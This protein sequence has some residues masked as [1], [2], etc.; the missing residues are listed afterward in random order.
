MKIGPSWESLRAAEAGPGCSVRPFRLAGRL[1]HEPP[2]GLVHRGE[3]ESEA[4]WRVAHDLADEAHG[5]I[6][7]RVGV[8]VG[9]HRDRGIE[10]SPIV[11]VFTRNWV[12]TAL[13]FV[14]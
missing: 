3:L 4:P 12:P 5:I 9:A 13:P 2:D 10:L 1:E 11:T 8:H 14:S 7:A 6:G